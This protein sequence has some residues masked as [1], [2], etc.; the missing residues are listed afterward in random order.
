[1]G[2]DGSA[3]WDAEPKL[4][5]QYSGGS[6][7]DQVLATWFSGN[8]SL[9]GFTDSEVKAQL[10]QAFGPGG[11]TVNLGGGCG[12]GGLI[13]TSG[14]VAAGNPSFA[15]TL[16]GADPFAT[17]GLLILKA[18][19]AATLSCGS[20]D[21]IL[22]GMQLTAPMSGGA[23]ALTIPIPCDSALVGAQFD[24]QWAVLPTAA[25]PCP[26]IGNASAS[27]RLRFTIGQ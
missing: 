23:A 6:A 25:A 4:A 2:L 7:G 10:L 16:S 8:M 26:L 24:A 1:M 13:S 19:G 27:S 12:A 14:D 9:F 22:P 17:L 11:G 18:A 20:C 15:I 5:S 21:V 3:T